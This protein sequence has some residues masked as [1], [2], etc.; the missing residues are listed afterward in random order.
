MSNSFTIHNLDPATARMLR[1]RAQAEGLSLNR[2]AKNLLAQALGVVPPDTNARRENFEE[3][4]GV[5]SE[6]EARE[7]EEAVVGLVR[8]DPGD[9]A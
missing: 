4:C 9:W 6:E 3:F 2:M 5:W 8:V 1:S 7:F